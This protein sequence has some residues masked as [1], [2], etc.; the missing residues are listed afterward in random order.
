[1]CFVLHNVLFSMKHFLWIFKKIHKKKHVS[2]Q[3]WFS[4][5]TSRWDFATKLVLLNF[6]VTVKVAPHECVNRTCLLKTWVHVKAENV[7]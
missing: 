7:V 4:R 5:I 3:R 1:M 6:L 2:I